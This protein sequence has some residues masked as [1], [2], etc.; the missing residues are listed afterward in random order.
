M[1]NIKNFYT[2][3][4]IFFGLFAAAPIFAAELFITSQSSKI[5]LNG[6][7][8]ANLFINAE[9]ENVNAIE[10]KIMYPNDLLEVKK[11]YDGNSIISFWVEKPSLKS[12]SYVSYSGIIPGGYSGKNGKVFS[13]VFQT[14]KEGL[15]SIVIRDVKL[16]MGDGKGTKAEAKTSGFQ[17]LVSDEIK[18]NKMAELPEIDVTPP[19]PFKPKIASN[20]KMF[21]GKWFLVFNAQDKGSG[22][23]RYLIHESRRIKGRIAANDWAEAEN[24]HILNDQ[25][26]KSYIYVK[27]VDKAGN[28]RLASLFPQNPLKWYENYIFWSIIILGAIIITSVLMKF[29]TNKTQNKDG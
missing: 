5:E 17:L 23:D 14:K 6:G 19:E 2:A 15:G 28:E 3:L 10:G 24:P 11:I 16:L 4:F 12:K 18:N 21:N 1:I 7:F 27:A 8:E 9:N 13:I 29:F 25:K 22:I 20:S 26:L